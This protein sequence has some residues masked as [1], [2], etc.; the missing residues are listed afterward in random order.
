MNTFL[1]IIKDAVGCIHN[2]TNVNHSHEKNIHLWY[3]EIS[4]T[5]HHRIYDESYFYIECLKCGKHKYNRETL[6]FAPFE[7]CY[8]GIHKTSIVYR[9]K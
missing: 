5:Y 7:A 1:K 9:Y 6:S 8:G 3:E 2:Y 4:P